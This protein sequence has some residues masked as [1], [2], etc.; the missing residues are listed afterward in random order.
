MAFSLAACG[1]K[2]DKENQ[3]A[4]WTRTGY[5]IDSDSNML[6]VTEDNGDWM[7]G[8][9]L[10]EK[11]YSSTI[12]QDGSALKGELTTD[13]DDD[14]APITVEVTED[15]KTG[16]KLVVDGKDTYTFDVWDMPDEADIITV[17]IDLAGDGWGHFLAETDDD[18]SEEATDGYTVQL[19]LNNTQPAE[20]TLTALPE[21]GSKFVEWRK[22]DGTTLSTEE[23][24]DITFDDDMHVICEFAL[25]D[26]K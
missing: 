11:A 14:A 6:S 4:E 17:T 5:F 22:E 8:C 23:K 1:A 26:Q 13:L 15:G 19:I 10:G 9:F 12:K 3:T 7:V 25:D 24:F 16:L 18:N 21:E 20:Y 2:V